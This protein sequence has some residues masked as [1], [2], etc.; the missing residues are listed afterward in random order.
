MG[1]PILHY[2]KQL[3]RIRMTDQ[4]AICKTDLLLYC[5]KPS[6]ANQRP[7]AKP[8]DLKLFLVIRNGQTKGLIQLQRHIYKKVMFWGEKSKPHQF[9]YMAI[10]VKIGPPIATRGCMLWAPFLVWYLR[11]P[12]GT[13]KRVGSPIQAIS[14]FDATL[15]YSKVYIQVYM[16]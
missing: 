5:S 11:V 3:Q 16:Y 15:V 6:E 10:E 1:I 4:P 8:L 2:Q 14:I 12:I 13:T 7:L 9:H